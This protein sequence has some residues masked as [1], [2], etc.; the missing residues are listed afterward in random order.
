V[1]RWA[2]TVAAAALLVIGCQGTDELEPEVPDETAAPDLDARPTIDDQLLDRS[3]EP[4]T[5]LVREDLVDGDGDEATAG[6]TVT[7]QYVGAA[8][9][10]GEEFDA[11]WDRGQPFTFPLG[12]GQVIEGWDRG[13]EGMREGGRRL[14]VIPPEQGY[15][16]RGVDG[17]IGPGETLVFVVDLLEVASG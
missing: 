7:V 10:T 8:W 1:R 3:G 5:E 2:A 16:E 17:V 14:L 4:P 13:V 9:S 12:A 11:S 15:G 6:D